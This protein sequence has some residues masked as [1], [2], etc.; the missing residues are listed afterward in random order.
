[1][2]RPIRRLI[3]VISA[4]SLV[5]L[6]V[7]IVWSYSAEPRELLSGVVQGFGFVLCFGGVGWVLV[8]RLPRNP[9]G[10]WFSF[11]AFTMS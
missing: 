5:L 8:R 10:W 3:D 6:V 11:S 9:V 4:V 2:S 1:M 7:G